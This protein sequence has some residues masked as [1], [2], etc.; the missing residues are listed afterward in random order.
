MG[1]S[2]AMLATLGAAMVGG[3]ALV[4]ALLA[5][6]LVAPLPSNLVNPWTRANGEADTGEWEIG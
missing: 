5:G 4:L 3:A 6:A 2:K 1:G